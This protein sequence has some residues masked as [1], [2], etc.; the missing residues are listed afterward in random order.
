MHFKEI[1]LTQ[2]VTA[3]GIALPAIVGAINTVRNGRKISATKKLL[4]EH[5]RWERECFT[6]PVNANKKN[7]IVSVD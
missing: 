6:S 1:D 2:L 3:I 5:D 4:T 7:G